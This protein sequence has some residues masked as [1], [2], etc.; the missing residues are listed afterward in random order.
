MARG[1][2]G[3]KLFAAHSETIGPILKA[4]KMIHELQWRISGVGSINFD[5]LGN[6]NWALNSFN[7][8]RVGWENPGKP[9]AMGKPISSLKLIVPVSQRRS[10]EI[11][12]VADTF[13]KSSDFPSTL[14][15][16]KKK[17]SAEAGTRVK[18]R[19]GKRE[20]LSL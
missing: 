10:Q 16:L 9:S 15:F 13:Q 11:L 1:W 12:P 2:E 14:L 20:S 7:A 8:V 18:Y 3:E 4:W 19:K 6:T 17:K 5:I